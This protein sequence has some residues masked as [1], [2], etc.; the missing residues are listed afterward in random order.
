MNYETAKKEKLEDAIEEKEQQDIKLK[1]KRQLEQA[2]DGIIRDTE[3][4]INKKRNALKKKIMEIRK[5]TERR[6]RLI[7]NK[8]NLIRGKMAAAVVV[9]NKVGNTETCKAK[10]GKQ[11]EINSYCDEF[12]INDVE[13]NKDCK[14]VENFCPIC[15]ETE[16]GTVQYNNRAKCYDMCDGAEKEDKKKEEPRGEW[17]WKV[18]SE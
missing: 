6:K 16:F 1:E 15:C 3:E 5:T 12:V 14:I 4:V 9:A 18:N 2:G 11:N 7:E 13:K 8:I 10:R 17:L